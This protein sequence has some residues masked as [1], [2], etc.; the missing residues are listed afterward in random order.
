ML[1]NS[2]SEISWSEKDKSCV[3]QF[4]WA[5]RFTEK[6]EE[7]LPGCLDEG[8]EEL[9][10]EYNFSFARKISSKDWTHN[11]NVHNTIEQYTQEWLGW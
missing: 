6:V 9:F 1:H 8:S 2:V 5:G 11:I 4:R 3:I 7:Q 10:P